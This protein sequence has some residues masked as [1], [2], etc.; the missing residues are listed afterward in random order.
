MYRWL[1]ALFCIGLL[2]LS[3]ANPTEASNRDAIS[4]ANIDR[5]EIAAVLSEIRTFN[6]IGYLLI[7]INEYGGTELLR[8]S[9]CSIINHE[10]RNRPDMAEET[11]GKPFTCSAVS[12]VLLLLFLLQ[13]FPLRRFEKISINFPF[14]LLF[15]KHLHEK[16]CCEANF[17]IAKFYCEYLLDYQVITGDMTHDAFNRLA[18][19]KKR[20]SRNRMQES[21]IT[22][23]YDFSSY[24]SLFKFNVRFRRPR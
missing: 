5:T 19:T 2:S 11:V 22:F 15:F 16:G 9:V 7:V 18:R 24:R 3:G 21:R 4:Y 14:F 20:I 13:A 23:Q 17:I 10:K 1:L 8:Q 6:A 12:P